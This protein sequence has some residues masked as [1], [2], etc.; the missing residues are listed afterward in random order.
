MRIRQC[1][2]T[3]N[4][5]RTLPCACIQCIG[6]GEDFS[7]E[8]IQLD[9]SCKCIQLMCGP[10]HF[11]SVSWALACVWEHRKNQN[12]IAIFIYC[13]KYCSQLSTKAHGSQNLLLEVTL[14]IRRLELF[15]IFH[16]SSFESRARL[17]PQVPAG[18]CEAGGGRRPLSAASPGLVCHGATPQNT[19][20][21]ELDLLQLTSD[22]SWS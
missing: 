15:L 2:L 17:W 9:L 8:R 11:S 6:G 14:N 5:G 20:K 19:L 22:T 21:L 12:P 18:V 1:Y 10:I 7:F 13:W 3:W 4:W 16:L